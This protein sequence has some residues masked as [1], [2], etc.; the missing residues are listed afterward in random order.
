V[1]AENKSTGTWSWQKLPGDNHH[2]DNFVGCSVLLNRAGANFADV[3]P[4]KKQTRQ[5]V[6]M[7]EVAEKFGW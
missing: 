2:F 3:R 6:T 4:F 5:R 1:K 7:A